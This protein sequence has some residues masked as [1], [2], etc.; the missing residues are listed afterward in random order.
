MSN[1]TTFETSF[2]SF[3]QASTAKTVQTRFQTLC[4]DLNLNLN[5]LF[6]KRQSRLVYKE[7]KANVSNNW[8]ANKL[9]E[10]FDK[11]LEHKDYKHEINHDDDC[12]VLIIGSGPVGLRLSIECALMGFK[13]TIIEKREK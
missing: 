9:W 12:H 13:C 7:I 3:L 5:D 8:K 10:K 2:N 6:A 1:S 11:R 4:S